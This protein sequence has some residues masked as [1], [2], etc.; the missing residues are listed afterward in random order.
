MSE[1][2][3]SWFYFHKSENAISNIFTKVKM[4]FP[5]FSHQWKTIFSQKWKHYIFTIVKMPFPWFS[6]KWKCLELNYIFTKVKMPCTRFSHKWKC[7]KFGVVHQLILENQLSSTIYVH[8][9]VGN[10][11]PC[12]RAILPSQTRYLSANLCCPEQVV[13]ALTNTWSDFHWNE[14]HWSVV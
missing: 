2:A 6:Q 7:F 10:F 3:L 9:R 12:M 11:P 13:K 1:N 8:A 5:W 14:I 4:P